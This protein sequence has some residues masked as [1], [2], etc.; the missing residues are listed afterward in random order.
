MSESPQPQTYQQLPPG[1]S[2][3]GSPGSGGGTTIIVQ[4]APQP[5]RTI[6]GAFSWL[7][8]M[9]T[10]LLPILLVLGLFSAAQMGPQEIPLAE[11]FYSGDRASKDKIAIVRIEGTI[12][13]GEGFPRKQIDQVL[14]DKNVKAVVLRV[15]SPG[16]TVTASDYILHHLKEMRE[17]RGIPLIAS[18]GSIAAS[19]GYYVAMAVGDQEKSIYAEPTTWTGS[20]GVIIPHYDFSGLMQRLEISEDSVASHRLKGMGNPAKKMTE[21][22]RQIF[23]SLVDESFSR[24]KSIVQSGRPGFRGEEGEKKLAEVATGQVFTADQAKASGLIDEVGFIEAAIA[25]AAEAAGLNAEQTKVVEYSRPTDI[26][27]LL[28]GV[29]SSKSEGLAQA[30]LQLTTPRAYYLFA[31][32]ST[33]AQ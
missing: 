17:K 33:A 7:F 8:R 3:Q 19:G 27:S 30:A 14:E 23:Q 24:F 4:Q 15:D 28:F 10:Y 13:D 26:Q 5:K 29:S 2:V 20:I 1:V 25:R 22:E 31:W 16:G 9:A 32:P 18:M 6:R 12:L 11:K 21:E